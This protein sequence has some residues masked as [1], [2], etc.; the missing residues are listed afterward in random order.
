MLDNR[1]MQVAT[2]IY[3]IGAALF[4]FLFLILLNEIL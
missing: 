3:A 2:I 4:I 1:G